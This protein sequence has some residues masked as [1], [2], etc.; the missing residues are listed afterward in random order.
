M[1][2]ELSEEVQA[3]RE[4]SLIELLTELSAEGERLGLRNALGLRPTDF[5]AAGFPELEERLARA[6]GGSNPLLQFGLRDWDAAAAIPHLDV[7]GSDP[8]WYLLNAEPEPF[9]RAFTAR[10]LEAA[11][12]HGR[13]TQVW[14]QAFSV[15]EGREDEL[16]MGLRVAAEMGAS[17]LAAWSYDGTASMSGIRPARPDVV[18]RVI[19]EAFAEL[20]GGR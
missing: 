10:T 15:P 7:F 18:W 14:V 5:A 11:G 19:G 8:Y 1:P 20:R 16:A 3:F 17:H 13:Q 12:R 6:A 2:Q 9:V 4:A